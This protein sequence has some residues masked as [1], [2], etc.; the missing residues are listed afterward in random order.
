MPRK[1]HGLHSCSLTD[2]RSARGARKPCGECALT[3]AAFDG[4]K[5]NNIR[6][7]RCS[8]CHSTLCCACLELVAAVAAPYAERIV[9]NN[10]WVILLTRPWR[11][12]SAAVRG[13]EQRP[14]GGGVWLL[15]CILC[16]KQRF[17]AAA[18]P[19]PLTLSGVPFMEL[20]PRLLRRVAF[21]IRCRTPSDDGGWLLLRWHSIEVLIYEQLVGD[22]EA[23]RCF[24]RHEAVGRFAVFWAPPRRLHGCDG[25]LVR[26]IV[27]QPQ[28]ATEGLVL[29]SAVAFGALA[30]C[31]VGGRSPTT[32]TTAQLAR[33]VY[34]AHEK[35]RIGDGPQQ[36]NVIGGGGGKSKKANQPGRFD[37]AIFRVMRV[38]GAFGWMR[39]VSPELSVHRK[40]LGSTR[41][42]A[43]VPR[44]AFVALP[45]R[46]VRQPQVEEGVGGSVTA[47]VE[48]EEEEDDVEDEEEE[49]EDAAVAARLA[50]EAVAAV[51]AAEAKAAAVA[52]AAIAAASA[53]QPEAESEAATGAIPI[54]MAPDA[55]G[56][57]SLPAAAQPAVAGADATGSEL[58][59]LL[60]EAHS[61]ESR[62]AVNLLVRSTVT[63]IAI[64]CILSEMQVRPPPYACPPP[65]PDSVFILIPLFSLSPL[66]AFLSSCRSGLTWPGWGR[67]QEK[68]SPQR[69]RTG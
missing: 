33:L 65:L 45:L 26:I 52:A 66:G 69:S 39:H 51:A 27:G 24:K 57:K 35:R 36:N 10:T 48:E 53:A 4:Q 55:Y 22:E 20:E 56:A 64:T 32:S 1:P 50:A 46:D 38:G 30:G 12:G 60:L 40:R 18:P 14:G 68:P 49:E 7:T 54:W 17:A 28:V 9:F 41:C 43:R 2:Q 58:E 3:R 31:L 16:V 21:P 62:D 19:L 61:D 13:F 5:D 59:A 23:R 67:S 29:L 6:F 25:L 37:Q 34:T 15:S 42:D 63:K 11:A 8:G 44:S 47:V